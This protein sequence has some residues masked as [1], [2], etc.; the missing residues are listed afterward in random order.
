METYLF[1]PEPIVRVQQFFG[2]GHEDLFTVF[3]MLG[4]TWGALLVIGL[5]FWIWGREAGYAALAAV[6]L[7]VLLK[8]GMNLL[9]TVP[10]PSA[11]A[12]VLYQDLETPSFPSGHV[13]TA[14]AA[15]SFL[16]F[17]Q[18]LS[19]LWPAVAAVLVSLGRMYLGSHYLVDVVVGVAVGVLIAWMLW[20]WWSPLW[21]RLCRISFRIYA[22]AAGLVAAILIVNLLMNAGIPH[23]WEVTGT[24]LGL[25]GGFLWQ[26]RLRVEVGNSRVM[27]I[28]LAGLIALVLGAQPISSLPIRMVVAAAAAVWVAVAPALARAVMRKKPTS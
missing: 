19:F 1:S 5:A 21:R 7:S 23:R 16:A 10:R 18:H 11:D 8:E 22:A 24:G 15:W 12:I 25:I 26:S 9:V 20:R 14:V 2:Y 3:S 17:R 28:G 6:V 27:L 13:V 4:E